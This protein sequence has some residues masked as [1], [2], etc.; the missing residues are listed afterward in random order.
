MFDAYGRHYPDYPGQQ[1]WQDPAYFRQ[2]GTQ[3]QMQPAQMSGA[4]QQG[5]APQS[6]SYPTI[7]ADIVQTDDPGV[8]ERWAV[9]QD[10]P[11]MF[12]NRDE[13][14]FIVKS[15]SGNGVTLD[16]YDKRPPAPPAPVFDPAAYVRKDELQ[17]LLAATLA[18]AQ[19]AKK[20]A[21]KEE[22]TA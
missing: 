19:P 4:Q 15:V 2:Q 6:M 3:Q 18:A 5:A 12:T 13:T 22:A 16:Y 14:V 17:E 10:R 11:Q 8:I 7:H 20:A 9:T 1:P 21:K